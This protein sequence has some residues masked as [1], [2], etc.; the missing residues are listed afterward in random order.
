MED[1]LTVDFGAADAVR[2]G[3]K[4]TAI[5]AEVEFAPAL[6]VQDGGKLPAAWKK[7]RSRRTYLVAGKRVALWVRKDVPRGWTPPLNWKRIH[8]SEPVY[9]PAD[10]NTK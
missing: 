1:F 4:P 3:R 8:V 2:R 9:I 10:E 7:G 5:L 6:L